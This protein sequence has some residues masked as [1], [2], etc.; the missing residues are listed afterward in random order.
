[1]ETMSNEQV[2]DILLRTE[3]LVFARIKPEQKL[4]VHGVPYSL[5]ISLYESYKSFSDKE[6]MQSISIFYCIISL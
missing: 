4:Q 1:M 6:T 2:E 5:A 3:E